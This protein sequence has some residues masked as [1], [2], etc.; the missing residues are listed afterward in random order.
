MQENRIRITWYGTASVRITAGDSQLLIDPFFPFP[1][2]RVKVDADAFAGCSRILVSHGHFDHIG[3][4]PFLVHPDTLISCT[5]A[6]YRSLCRMGVA[7]SHLHRIAAGDTFLS[8]DFRI[9]AIKGNHSKLGTVDI[10]KTLC[11]ER[12][13]RNRNGLIRKIRTIASCREK[14]ESL[15]YLIEVYGRRILI[16]GSL[17][18]AADTAYPEGVDLALFP[19]QGF[20]SLCQIASGICRQLR[21][22]AILLTHFDDTFPPFS[23]EVD[24]A[25]FTASMK[26]HTAVCQLRHGGTLIL[27]SDG[28]CR[29]ESE[30]A[31]TEAGHENN[32]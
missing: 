1:E 12:V 32:H 31:K 3:S 27:E 21:P 26:Q 2:S 30:T 6:P 4:I 24:T 13:L 20:G 25:E 8:G 7:E 14:H 9:T 22:A 11:S 5:N 16:L 29:V 17:A 23:T 18:L 15:C 28:K 10:L 19:Y